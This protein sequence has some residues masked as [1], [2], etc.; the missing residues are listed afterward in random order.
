MPVQHLI[1]QIHIKKP[2]CSFQMMKRGKVYTVSVV[3]NPESDALQLV[4]SAGSL[5][6]A[7]AGVRRWC[8]YGI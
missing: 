5:D 2:V 1:P 4:L 8:E 3:L 6:L 7:D